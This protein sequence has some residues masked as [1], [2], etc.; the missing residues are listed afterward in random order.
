MPGSLL[1]FGVVEQ[2]QNSW[3]ASANAGLAILAFINLFSYLDRY[4]VSGGPESLK[5]SDL[6]LSDTNLGSV[7]S[8]FLVVYT[9]LAPVFGALGDRRS[10]PRLVAL[11]GA[12]VSFGP[13]LSGFAANFLTLFAARAAG[14]VGEAAYGTIAP[15]LLSD[16]FP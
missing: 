2:K 5:N 3:L 13:A 14:G 8:G 7:M 4:V 12:C 1:Y 9:L 11:G 16:Y 6:G 10:R 15:S